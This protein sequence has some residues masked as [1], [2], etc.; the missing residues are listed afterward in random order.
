VT[1]LDTHALVWFAEDHPH[2]G[3]RTTI[4]VNR[5]LARDELAVSAL[6]FWEITMLV[7]KGRLRM[8]LPPSGMRRKVLEQ[9]VREIVLAGDL[10]IEAARLPAF[11]GDPADRMIVATALATGATL[12]T[13][14]EAILGWRG[15][16]K[17]QDARR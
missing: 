7:D 1:V 17:T 13:A 3:R 8:D 9:G 14:D 16:L 10:A 11:H 2:L 12:V 4:L 5:A 15:K 6:S